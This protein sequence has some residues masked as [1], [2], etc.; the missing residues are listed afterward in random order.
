MLVQLILRTHVYVQIYV[1]F[2]IIPEFKVSDFNVK[3]RPCFLTQTL[4]LIFLCSS[5]RLEKSGKCECET[6]ALHYIALGT[7]PLRSR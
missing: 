3:G 7:F 1:I 4:R 2:M 6:T 5:T